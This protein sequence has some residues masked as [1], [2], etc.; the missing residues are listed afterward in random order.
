ML[1]RYDEYN[2]HI[3]IIIMKYVN[4]LH[5]KTKIVLVNNISKK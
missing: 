4:I 5:L 2:D 3:I 1:T